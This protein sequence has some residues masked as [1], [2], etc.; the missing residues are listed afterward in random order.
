MLDL[1]REVNHE[2]G[3]VAGLFSLAV[4][5]EEQGKV[6]LALEKYQ[7]VLKINPQHVQAR[8]KLG[9]LGFKED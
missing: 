7:E 5:Y 6:D 8:Q 3:I 4:L 1:Y 9:E 2:P